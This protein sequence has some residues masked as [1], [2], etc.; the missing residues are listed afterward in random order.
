MPTP[1]FVQ[2]PFRLH[3]A[4]RNGHTEQSRIRI[5]EVGDIIYDLSEDADTVYPFAQQ[6]LSNGSLVELSTGDGMAVIVPDPNLTLGPYERLPGG[7]LQLA[8]DATFS[9][10]IANAISTPP[11]G[12]WSWFSSTGLLSADCN[13]STPGALRILYNPAA[14]NAGM[15]DA[16]WN[17]PMIRKRI[18]S[19]SNG[20]D[21][22]CRIKSFDN[23][24]GGTFFMNI[25]DPQNQN[26]W[27][28]WRVYDGLALP[29]WTRGTSSFGTNLTIPTT[30]VWFRLSINAGS[31]ISWYYNT[32]NQSTPPQT[33]TLYHTIPGTYWYQL[34]FTAPYV[35]FAVEKYG[36]TSSLGG[37]VYYCRV[38]QWGQAFANAYPGADINSA[39]TYGTRLYGDLDAIGYPTSGPAITL[40]SSSDLVTAS[41]T[42]SNTLLQSILTNV[43]NQR[44]CDTADWTFSAV[45]GSSANPA[46]STYQAAAS[47]TVSG[48]GRYFALYAKC[49]SDGYKAGS[50]FLPQ[51]QIPYSIV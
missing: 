11:A 41:A 43:A 27:F 36:A 17:A 22:I 31:D 48:T 14:G 35:G 32:T 12:G 21:F 1:Y 4:P 28:S 29:E 20:V 23:S 42:I 40:V 7:W 5:Y 13:V 2:S 46:A 16:T 19:G 15:G 25:M 44:G 18:V 3:R 37:D 8:P 47:C 33:W 9:T 30:P 39:P 49:T 26:G 24:S 10:T 6:L 34:P 38:R 45:R 51:I 50:L